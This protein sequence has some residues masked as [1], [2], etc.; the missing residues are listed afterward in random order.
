MVSKKKQR[1]P[2][3]L[4]GAETVLSRV[5]AMEEEIPGVR[6]SEDIECLH[7]MRVASRRLRSAA[8]APARARI[9]TR[10]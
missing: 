6:R 2:C 10:P 3:R 4:L 8:Q 7:R 9:R 1:D 5:D